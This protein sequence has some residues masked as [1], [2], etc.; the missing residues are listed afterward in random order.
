MHAD[1]TECVFKLTPQK[2]RPTEE[3]ML[4]DFA[5]EGGAGEGPGSRGA[6]KR[7]TGEVS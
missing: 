7:N 1:M 2:T 3:S 4:G 5:G 6:E